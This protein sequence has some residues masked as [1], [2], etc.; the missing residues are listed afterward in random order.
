ME[1]LLFVNKSNNPNPEYAKEGDSGFDLRAWITEEDTDKTF[2][3]L[4]EK[5]VPCVVLQ[6]LQR[7][8]I[9]TGLYFEIPDNFEVQVRPRSGL[10]LK[11][12]LSVLNTPGTVDTLYRGE[13]C[14]IVV[15]LSNQLIKI[16][17]GDRIAQAVVMPREIVNLV[18]IP[19]INEDT[20]RGA[21]G[22]GS[23]GV[24]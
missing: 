15:N 10:A 24:K 18:E 19:K 23:S 7:K 22:M 14:V 5:N 11:Q 3:S 12:G 21:D 17:S 20:E 9:H 16:E 6:P 1:N 13:I 8:L 2:S 4:S